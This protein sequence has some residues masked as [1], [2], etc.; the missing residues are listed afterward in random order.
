M[1]SEIPTRKILDRD[2]SH[3]A[4]DEIR[5]VGRPALRKIVDEGIRV[6]ERCSVSARGKDEHIGLLFTFLHTLELVDAAEVSLDAPTVTGA[7]LVLRAAFEGMLAIEWTARDSDLRYGAAY[8]VADIHRRIRAYQQYS[9]GHVDRKRLMATLAS[10][11]LSRDITLPIEPQA[12]EKITGFKELLQREHLREAS[13]EY[14]ATA[15]RIGKP[16]PPFYSLWNGPRSVE[17]LARRL[18][19]SGE[20]EILYRPWSRTQHAGDVAQRLGE[21]DGLP[22]VRPFRDPDG[23]ITAYIFALTFGVRVIHTV[24]RFYRPGE[25]ESAFPAWYKQH[26]YAALN[27]LASAE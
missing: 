8:V 16:S 10:D 4:T 27:R 2:L 26:V 19:H 22:A 14:S 9:E 20:Y 7:N 12:A 6:F 18:G 11:P 5:A 21:K 17:E 25:A 24:L 23:L 13:E 3:A 1:R 15:V